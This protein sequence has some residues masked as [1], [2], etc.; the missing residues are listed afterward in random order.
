MKHS[1][2]LAMMALLMLTVPQAAAAHH[3]AAAFDR[4]KPVIVEGTLKSFDWTN[5]HTWMTMVVPNG[6]GGAEEWRLEGPSVSILARN[7]WKQDSIRPGENLRLL[8][9]PNRDGSKGGE[10]LTVKKP[11]GT[12]LKFGIV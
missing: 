5:P 11:D 12:V 1:L 9:A 7:G 2:G 8:V 10:F 4:S 6:K 3:S